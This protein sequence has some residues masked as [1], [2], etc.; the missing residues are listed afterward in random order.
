MR[1]DP[2]AWV[3]A[4]NAICIEMRWRGL[5]AM[6]RPG[7]LCLA[8]SRWIALGWTQTPRTFYTGHL[9]AGGYRTPTGIT[10]TCSRSGLVKK[11]WAK[12]NHA[13]QAGTEYGSIAA[14]SCY[15]SSEVS[16]HPRVWQVFR[17][18]GLLASPG[19]SHPWKRD[20]SSRGSN[21]QSC[22]FQKCD[23]WEKQPL[24]ETLCISPASDALSAGDDVS[25]CSLGPAPSM[26]RCQ[27]TIRINSQQ[28]LFHSRRA[29]RKTRP[30][31]PE[32]NMPYQRVHSN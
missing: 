11:S 13:C 2:R 22:A 16:W 19:F 31:A 30:T 17:F 14:S 21:S 20:F 7:W 4:A 10:L 24:W 18:D 15:P 23:P 29:R 6:D 12:T 27:L 3:G 5:S 26:G 28:R 25:P 1:R 8:P 32:T 9:P